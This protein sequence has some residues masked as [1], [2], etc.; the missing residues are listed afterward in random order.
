MNRAEWFKFKWLWLRRFALLA[1][2]GVV[3]LIAGF[4][5]DLVALAVVGGLL[6][7]PLIFWLAFIPILHWKERYIGGT[8]SVWGAFLVFETSSWS[9]IFYW[10]VHVIPDWR[11]SGQYADA[12]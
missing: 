6:L 8:S 9:K 10:F 12:P 11:Q 1:V 4:A 2:A 3:L 5:S 7:A